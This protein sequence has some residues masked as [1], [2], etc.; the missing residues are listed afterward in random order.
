MQRKRVAVEAVYE[1]RALPAD[2]KVPG[3]KAAGS[4]GGA[5]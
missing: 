4:W 2:H 5:I 1:S 3:D